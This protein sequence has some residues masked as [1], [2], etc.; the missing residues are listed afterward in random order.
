MEKLGARTT[1]DSMLEGLARKAERIIGSLAV[2][3]R[4]RTFSATSALRAPDE[5]N[6]PLPPFRDERQQCRL[7]LVDDDV[8]C[9]GSRRNAHPGKIPDPFRQVCRCFH[10]P[11][12]SSARQC[13]RAA[14]G[15]S[16]STCARSPDGHPRARQGGEAAWRDPWRSR[17]CPG[18]GRRIPL[19]VHRI[20]QGLIARGGW[21]VLTTNG[22]AQ[23]HRLRIRRAATRRARRATPA[24]PGPRRCR[25]S[26]TIR[27]STPRRNTGGHP[28]ESRST[29]GSRWHRCNRMPACFSRIHVLLGRALDAVRPE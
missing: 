21:S 22:T 14:S 6:S 20:A 27:I 13:R 29:G 3:P 1:L 18:R 9:G 17:R 24:L 15:C 7:D 26:P 8:G 10:V 19:A 16:R 23:R 28:P 25:G 4:T 5:K 11:R 2:S 12:R